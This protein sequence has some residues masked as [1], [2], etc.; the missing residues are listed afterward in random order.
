MKKIAKILMVL[1]IAILIINCIPV[2]TNAAATTKEAIKNIKPDAADAEE[3]ASDLRNIVGKFLGLIQVVSALLSVVLIAYI[4]FNSIMKSPSEKTDYIK[5]TQPLIVG[6]IMIFMAVSV[7]KL[8]FGV[9][10]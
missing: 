7:V 1:C 2:V 5:K 4:G 3:A 10:E 6:I 9:L 8:I